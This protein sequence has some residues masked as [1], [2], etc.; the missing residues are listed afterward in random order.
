MLNC[1]NM[2]VLVVCDSSWDNF[3][4][5]SRRL[6]SNNIDP[7]HR[8]NVFYGKQMK[9]INAL[10]SKNMLQVYRIC[11]N[12][13]TFVEDLRMRLQSTKFCII[14]HNFTEY[15]TISAVIINICQENCIPYFVF[16][17]HTD[18]FFYNGDLMHTRFKKCILDVQDISMRE[19][20]QYKPDFEITFPIEINTLKDYSQIVHKLRTSYKNI[21]D[22]KVKRSTL[23]IDEKCH[24]QYNYI[25]YM[26]SKKKWLKEVIPK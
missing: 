4:E 25:E 1:N 23:F 22:T 10:C 20:I 26:A 24:K 13:K 17:E 8:I 15:N 5:M 21:D 9:H 14:F 19:N 16:S 3:A 6:T 18:N 12:T 7:T 2:N 11:I